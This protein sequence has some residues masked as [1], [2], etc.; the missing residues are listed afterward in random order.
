MAGKRKRKAVS[1]ALH[2][3][4]TEYSSLLRALSTS[5]TLDLARRLT[6][7]PPPTKRK[8]RTA[9]SALGNLQL[10]APPEEYQGPLAEGEETQPPTAGSSQLPPE[11]PE[12]EQQRVR[13]RDTWTRWPL[14]PTDLHVPEWGLDDEIEPLVRQC[15]RNNPHPTDEDGEPDDTP[16]WLP[17]LTESA[18]VFLSSVFALLSHHTPARPQS[19]QDRLNPIDW[20]MV[21]DILGTCGDV[22]ATVI[23]TVKARMEAIYGP[24][25]SPAIGRLQTRA[26]AKSRAAAAFDEADDALFVA[27]RP[28]K[29]QPKRVLEEVESDDLDG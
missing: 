5:D 12:G 28:T 13:K 9:K 26:E 11:E 25:D 21:L 4:L 20:K 8:K 24:Y 15:L 10:E 17:H 16:S 6:E 18:S 27:P 2:S 22:D 1:H 14:L 23:T 7:P 3:E 19:M 29:R